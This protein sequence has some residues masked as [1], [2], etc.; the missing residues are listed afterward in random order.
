[1][2]RMRK[3]PDL[4]QIRAEKRAGK[5]VMSH[6]YSHKVAIMAIV[7]YHRREM[8]KVKAKMEEATTIVKCQPSITAQNDKNAVICWPKPFHRG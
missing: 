8:V 3:P 6:S 7:G 5:Q 2:I 1:M 4:L